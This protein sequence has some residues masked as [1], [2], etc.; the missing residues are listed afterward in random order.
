MKKT[1]YIIIGTISLLLGTMGIFLPVLPTTPF[2]LLTAWL[3]M[4]S[5]DRLY[6]KVMS[7]QYFGNTVYNYQKNKAI[8]MKSRIIAITTL[9]LSISFSIYLVE[10]LWVRILLLFTALCVTI[11]LCRMKTLRKKVVT[12]PTEILTEK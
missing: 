10:I 9:W 3:Y 12:C 1:V 4:K 11:H 5:S 2:Y 6:A 7:N 8:T